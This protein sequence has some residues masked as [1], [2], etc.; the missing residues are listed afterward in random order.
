MDIHSLCKAGNLDKV[1]QYVDGG[2]DLNSQC[3]A[4]YSL[5]ANAVQ[6]KSANIVQYL[7]TQKASVG[8][9][10]LKIVICYNKNKEINKEFSKYIGSNVGFN[11]GLNK[12]ELQQLLS[13]A[14]TNNKIGITRNLLKHRVDVDMCC[15][16]RRNLLCV[17]IE[18]KNYDMIKC[19]VDNKARVTHN[20]VMKAVVNFHWNVQGQMQDVDKKY[21]GAVDVVKCLLSKNVV[22]CEQGFKEVI[23]KVLAM[24]AIP[25]AKVLFDHL[26]DP[27]KANKTYK[28]LETAKQTRNFDAVEYFVSKGFHVGANDLKLAVI[29][30]ITG[31]VKG[32]LASDVANTL[33]QSEWDHLLNLALL[34]QNSDIA[35]M[36][37][38]R[39]ADMNLQTVNQG[40]STLHIAA[41]SDNTNVVRYLVSNGANVRLTD[42]R[43]YTPYCV[44]QIRS[45]HYLEREKPAEVYGPCSLHLEDPPPHKKIPADVVEY[46]Q[47][48]YK[49][50]PKLDHLCRVQ[51]R[52]YITGPNLGD[53]VASLPIPDTLKDFVMFIDFSRMNWM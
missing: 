12:T 39:G 42:K 19:L 27:N 13:L 41:Q 30:G 11:L 38:K 48:W 46:L 45:A 53:K 23:H 15:K 5:L 52:R 7:L 3:P 44:A 25:L 17:A 36:F 50:F 1:K 2:G 47:V 28:I 21:I 6:A 4:G 16:Q 49:P 51:V 9:P 24:K 22:I 40:L 8:F 26:G 32:L 20:E 43:G 18:N 33:D 34:N 10:E 14:V 37:I 31:Y 35:L 29:E